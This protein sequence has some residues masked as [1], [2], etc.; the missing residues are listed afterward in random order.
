MEQELHPPPAVP[1]LKTRT[2]RP[3]GGQSQH[4]AEA[5]CA[6]AS[7]F[8]FSGALRGVLRR[9]KARQGTD[10]PT[11]L[12][13]LKTQNTASYDCNTKWERL[14]L[15][16]PNLYTSANSFRK[17]NSST[18]PTLVEAGGIEPPSESASSGTSPGAE[19]H[20]HS[21]T[22]AWAH[23]LTSLVASLCM[24]RSKLCALTFAADQ[25]PAAGPR[26]SRRGRS[27]LRQREEQYLRC[28]LIYNCPF[29][30]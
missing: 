1:R 16:L 24:V 25:R 15:A 26:P 30:G 12:K 27:L 19:S 8:C 14:Y 18:L 11:G 23:T 10:T 28:S 7:R 5:R 22:R 20:L 9:K 13:R 3:Q 17:K 29:L 21:L 4:R 2:S 6:P